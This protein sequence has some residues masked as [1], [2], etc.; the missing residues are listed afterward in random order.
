MIARKDLAISVS[1]DV[2]SP[3]STRL[4]EMERAAEPA[5]ARAHALASNDWAR[6]EALRLHKSLLS[7]DE[8]EL[9]DE[10][11]N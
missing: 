11:R 8:H 1:V 10:S 7:H 2:W 9:K 4:I 6:P 5:L 3:Q